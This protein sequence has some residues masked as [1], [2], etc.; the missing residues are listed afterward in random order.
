MIKVLIRS[1][2]D[3]LGQN[4]KLFLFAEDNYAIIIADLRGKVVFFAFSSIIMIKLSE[5]HPDK[6]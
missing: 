3:T 1:H 5:G 4:S 2:L 6:S